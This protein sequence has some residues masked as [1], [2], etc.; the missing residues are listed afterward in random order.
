MTIAIQS[1][2]ACGARQYPSRDICWN[3]LS[4]ALPFLE[5]SGTG[6]VLAET[7]IHRSLEAAF[8]PQ[9]P[10]RVATVLLDSG[11]RLLCFLEGGAAAGDR[12]MLSAGRNVRQEP[13]WIARPV[14]AGAGAD[15]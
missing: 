6:R 13:V 4:D 7:V 8:Q 3:C 1:C 5:D 9:L 15:R 2:A 12:V 10:V 11:P 14:S